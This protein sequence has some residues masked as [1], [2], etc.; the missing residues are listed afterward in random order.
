MVGR[1]PHKPTKATR[2]RVETLIVSM[3]EERI[4]RLIGISRTTLR[5]HYAD[6]L[7]LGRDRVQAETEEALRRG[8]EAGKPAAIRIQLQRLAAPRAAGGDDAAPRPDK[9]GKKEQAALDATTAGDGTEW[10]D[11]LRVP[12]QPLN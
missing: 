10:G 11:D 9:L 3:S 5:A 8:V 1:P 4:A 12:G 7:S 2:R 6:E